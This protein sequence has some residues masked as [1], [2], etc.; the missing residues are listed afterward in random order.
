MTV[1]IDGDGVVY[2][3]GFAADSRDGDVSH[4]L[5]N[6]KL[7]INSAM[8]KT[9]QTECSVFLTSKDPAVNFRTSIYPIYKQNRVK[10]SFVK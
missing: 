9:G 6:A 5:H 7:L 2:M 3:A 4:S 10:V 8:D 1:N